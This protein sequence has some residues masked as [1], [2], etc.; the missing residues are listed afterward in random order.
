VTTGDAVD[1]DREQRVRNDRPAREIGRAANV[2]TCRSRHNHVREPH[3]LPVGEL[4]GGEN[5]SLAVTGVVDTVGDVI[6]VWGRFGGSGTNTQTLVGLIED[7][8]ERLGELGVAIRRRANRRSEDVQIN[9]SPR[10]GG[11]GQS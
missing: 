1:I 4:L 3:T 2:W 5:R 8:P 11:P 9:R 6:G 7:D 10:K